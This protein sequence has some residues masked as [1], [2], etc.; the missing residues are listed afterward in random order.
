M[1]SVFIRPDSDDRVIEATELNARRMHILGQSRRIG[2]A[3][4]FPA[5]KSSKPEQAENFQHLRMKLQQFLESP[6]PGKS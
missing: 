2:K 5:F 3:T 1:L 4:R 6:D